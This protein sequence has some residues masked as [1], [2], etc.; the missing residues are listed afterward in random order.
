MIIQVLLGVVK[1][2]EIRNLTYKIKDKCLFDDISITIYDNDIIFL[3]G[4]NGSGKSTL[5]NIISNAHKIKRITINKTF[6]ELFYLADKFTLINN[7]T[8]LDNLII[9]NNLFKSK[10]NVYYLLDSLQIENRKV[11]K[12][13]KGNRQKLGLALSLM[14]SADL[15]LIDEALDGL[16]NESIKAFIKLVR[17]LNKALVIVTHDNRIYKYKNV[18][19]LRIEE[20]KIYEV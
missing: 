19:R 17:E 1:L 18:R 8:S 20:G 7:K 5:L 14:S 6:K 4:N 3:L 2:L 9:F 15:I 12:L 16:D 11:S 10:T 13:S